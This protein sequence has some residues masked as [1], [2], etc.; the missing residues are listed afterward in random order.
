MAELKLFRIHPEDNVAVAVSPIKKGE[1]VTLGGQAY[2]PL[3]DIPAG[4]KMAIQPI[5]KGE[6]VVKYGF[7][8]GTAKEDVEP[9]TWMHTHNVKSKLGD[10]LDYKYEPAKAHHTEVKLDKNY[11]F[12]GYLRED[13]RVG[14]RNEVWIIPTV[15]STAF[16]RTA[17]RMA[18]RSLTG[19]RSARRKSSPASYTVRMPAPCLCSRSAARTTRS[20]S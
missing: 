9:G 19:T 13:G 20:R 14:I 1:T 8:I 17:I 6:D 4:H 3:G 2:T 12:D 10:L 15:A 7:P 16:S 18:A 5:K 11:T